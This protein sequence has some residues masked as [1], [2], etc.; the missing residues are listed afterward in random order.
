MLVDVA[1]PYRLAGTLTYEFD[2]STKAVPGLR[3]VVPL[4]NRKVIGCLLGEAKGPTPK[5]LR[6]IEKVLDETP[7]LTIHQLKLLTW[8]SRYYFTPI[9]EVLRHLLPPGLFGKEKKVGR[10]GKPFQTH[11]EFE[12]AMSVDLNSEQKEIIRR[13]RDQ[14][15]GPFLLQGVT[16]S[17]K[18]E[19]YIDLARE[20]VEKGNQVLILVPEISLTPQLIG[21]F[22]KALGISI[23][24]YHSRLT[25]AQR[26]A[27]WLTVR[28]K[29]GSIVVGT[30]SAIF[31]PFVQLKLIVVDEEHDPSYKQEERFCYN[32]RDLALWRGKEE[33]ARILLGSATPSLESLHRTRIG[34][35]TLLQLTSRPEGTT[36][37]QVKL[38]D[39]RLSGNG[40]LSND[41][42][43]AIAENLRR[44]EQSLIFLNRRGFAPFFLCRSCGLIPR[45][46][47]CEISLAY[48]KKEGKLVCHYCDASEKV[49]ASCPR[50][51]SSAFSPKGVGTE[52][53]EEEL[54]EKYPKARIERLDRDTSAGEGLWKIL[55]RMKKKEIDIL[56]GTQTVGK[57]HDY[58]DLTLVG[59]VDAD[60]AMNLPDFRAAERTFQ[61]ITQVS[62]RSGRGE[63]PGQ[64]FVQTFFPDHPGLLA[65][66]DHD[67][68]LFIDAELAVRQVAG[69]PP[70]CRLIR[71]VLSGQDEK[72]VASSIRMLSEKVSRVHRILGPAPCPLSKIRGKSRWH[73]LIKSQEFLKL[74]SR[75]QPIL[76]GFSQNELPSGVRMLVNVDPVEMM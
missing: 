5:G 12:P 2:S 29:R 17:G 72:K 20:E 34:K 46:Q 21:R 52:K 54:K 24:P 8:A 62:G 38:I 7:L 47:G 9:G 49:P 42:Q 73:L 14:S 33:G 36:L 75:L 66:R 25:P 61:L 70:Y 13:I 65:A 23:T 63:K 51:H 35:M 27:S 19:I 69:Y 74:H 76:D 16:G 58:P 22:Q 15:P 40:I 6:R 71:I 39:R 59:V 30:R 10:K 57:G 43:A 50:C 64:V 31:L 67:G 68:K 37:P 11:D 56:V 48:H 1:L 53:I 32:A 26:L 4:G 28:E 45:C 41:L 55:S 18:T 60:T 3:V 44:G